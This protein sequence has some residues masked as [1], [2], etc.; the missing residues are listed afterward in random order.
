MFG[1]DVVQMY[2][3]A[4][5]AYTP[6]AHVKF[7]SDAENVRAL[8][9]LELKF[10]VGCDCKWTFPDDDAPPAAPAANVLSPA[11]AGDDDAPPPPPAPVDPLDFFCVG[12]T[13]LRTVALCMLRS[14]SSSFLKLGA[15]PPRRHRLAS[16][17]FPKGSKTSRQNQ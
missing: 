17:W 3:T 16:C 4:N 8:F 1:F 13:I 12:M 9:A 14:F 11:A 5:Q 15:C 7:A 10:M 6:A 2:K